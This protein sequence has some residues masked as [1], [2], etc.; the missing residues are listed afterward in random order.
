M[1]ERLE[2][3]TFKHGG[4][5]DAYP[6]DEWMDGTVWKL[7]RGEDFDCPARTF[8]TRAHMAAR[9]RGDIKFRTNTIDENTIV[10]Q[11]YKP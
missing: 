4:G 8:Q 7:V 5:K 1:A 10:I 2:S 9:H 6:W 3:F 11:A